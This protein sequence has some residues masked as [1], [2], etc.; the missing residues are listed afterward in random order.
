M[1]I[2]EE[3]LME[4]ENVLGTDILSFSIHCLIN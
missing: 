1:T 2:S 3:Y 4:N